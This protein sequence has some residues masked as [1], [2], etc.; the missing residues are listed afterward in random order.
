MKK[1][2]IYQQLCR[3][4]E[5][6]SPFGGESF[7]L[8]LH[9]SDHT[10]TGDEQA[11]LSAD[12][13]RQGCRY[14]VCAGYKCSSWDDSVDMADLERNNWEVRDDTFV[15]TTWHENESIEDIVFFFLN[16]TSF[17]NWIPDNFLVLV[18]GDE[19]ATLDLIRNEINRQDIEQ[20]GPGYPPQGVVSPDP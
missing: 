3:P 5:F 2:I 12:I 6:I 8:C 7:A 16:N 11:K 4:Y 20:A 15:M 14:A 9:I 17:D 1:R 10:L 19:R 18:L 13:V